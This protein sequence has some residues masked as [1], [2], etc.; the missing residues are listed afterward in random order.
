MIILNNKTKKAQGTIG[1]TLTQVFATFILVVIVAIFMVFSFVLFKASSSQNSLQVIGTGD[2]RAVMTNSFIAFL[3]TKDASGISNKD[4]LTQWLKDRSKE[5]SNKFL[6]NFQTY[7]LVSKPECTLLTILPEAE[8]NNPGFNKDIISFSSDSYKFT[9]D[10]K[11]IDKNS[12]LSSNGRIID[13]FLVTSNGNLLIQ[14]YG[15]KCS[16]I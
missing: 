4:I 16:L 10:E 5:S 2:S 12:F 1:F 15:G 13:I 9:L 7:L 11:T 8:L 6:E 3:N 14:F